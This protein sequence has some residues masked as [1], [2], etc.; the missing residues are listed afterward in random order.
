MEYRFNH[1]KDRVLRYA[2]DPSFFTATYKDK[3][4]S[5][6]SRMLWA[7]CSNRG[8]QLT[9]AEKF[10]ENEDERVI[11]ISPVRKGEFARWFAGSDTV[12]YEDGV[13]VPAF[14]AVQFAISLD[15]PGPNPEDRGVRHGSLDEFRKQLVN[16]GSFRTALHDSYVLSLPD[17]DVVRIAEDPVV[18]KEPEEEMEK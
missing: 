9:T 1:E 11:S 6:R 12:E 10:C 15:Q 2:G 14:Y 16:N 4:G 5:E 18:W 7:C 3:N 13:S 17:R 8:Q